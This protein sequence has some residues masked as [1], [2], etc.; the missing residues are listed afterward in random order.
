MANYRFN[1]RCD[2]CKL[3][4]VPC[5]Y[6]KF[7]TAQET[8]AIKKVRELACKDCPCV[9][10]HGGCFRESKTGCKNHEDR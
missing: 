9:N 1:K 4:D 10:K 6:M 2:T 7:A 5:T 3:G 8:T